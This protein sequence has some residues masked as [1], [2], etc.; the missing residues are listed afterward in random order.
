MSVSVRRLEN[1]RFHLSIHGHDVILDGPSYRALVEDMSALLERPDGLGSDDETAEF[2]F[3][4]RRGNDVGIQAL[5]R[6]AEHE[7]V[8]ALL[9]ASE[10]DDLA[11]K[12][13]VKNM[14]RNSRKIFSEDVTF[15]YAN[16]VP[17]GEINN[18]IH[19]LSATVREIEKEGT[20]VFI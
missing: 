13:L 15:R 3:N 8:L 20:P 12:K 18:A 2:L 16:G 11:R 17:D 6:V 14:G 10:K 19:R 1:D 5:L 4:V 9:K 7:D